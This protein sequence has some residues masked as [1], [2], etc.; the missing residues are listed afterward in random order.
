[1]GYWKPAIGYVLI[2]LVGIT[3]AVGI[4]ID[5]KN[6]YGLARARYIDNSRADSKAA[7]R[8]VEVAYRSIYE[9]LRT[10]S[11]LPGVMA[12]DRHGDNLTPE[13]L[14]TIQQIYNN[15]A[16]NVSISE[17][18]ILPA[19]F[20]PDRTDPATGKGEMPILEFDE[21]V[22]NARARHEAASKGEKLDEEELERP[23]EEIEIF[24][25]RELMKQLAW[26][27]INYP[28]A[29]SI[30]G[31]KVPLVSS[32]EVIT[33]DNTNFIH[34][35]KDSD[36]L[37]VIFSVPFYDED[38]ALKGAISAIV[39]TSVLGKMLPNDNY[40]IVNA[41]RGYSSS[42]L[43]PRMSD[44]SLARY[45]L[46][47]RS[48]I[49]SETIPLDV[50]DDV[51]AWHLWAGLPD[52]NFTDSIEVSS[53]RTME[54]VAEASVLGLTL[55][56]MVGWM[57]VVRTISTQ[58]RAS[59]LL[60]QR[61]DERT[62][63]IQHIATHDTLTG[64]PN[65]RMLGGRM[66]ALL[67]VEG[68]PP[69]FAVH[70]I[71]LDRFKPVNDSL[72]HLVGDELLCFVAKRLRGCAQKGVLIARFGGDEFIVL[73]TDARG[74]KD[75][76]K[77]AQRMIAKLSEEFHVQGH[78]VSIGASVGIAMYP[79]DGRTSDELIRN[80]DLALYRA[81]SEGRGVCRTFEPAMYQD[82]QEAR[83]L[84]VELREAIQRKQFVLH[85][86]PLHDAATA[87]LVGF[88]ALVR[89]NHPERG[90]LLPGSFIGAAEETGLIRHL[91]AW[92]LDQACSDAAEWPSNLTVAVNISPVQFGSESLPLQVV[93]ALGNAGLPPSRLELEIT[94]SVM[95]AENEENVR[96]LHSLRRMG[97]RIAMDD[98]GTG[99]SALRYLRSFP[100]DRIKID[101][102][103][104]SRMADNPQGR[105]IVRAIA[106]L[107]R[108]LGISTTA[109]GV[110][111]ESDL[112]LVRDSGCTDAQGYHFGRP[113]PL[114]DVERMLKGGQAPAKVA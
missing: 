18:Y 74:R 79:A 108:S 5:I 87:R 46:P 49:Y 45:L 70:C 37:G 21:L 27:R 107:A 51:S 92:I 12:I 35:G 68:G 23:A 14:T 82:M 88:E 89:W 15:L 62:A 19:D 101:R 76:E 109:E 95:L 47:D 90:L 31:M 83:A 39:L 61:V 41:S 93:S 13:A 40:T 113:M 81:K 63:E 36:R 24:E 99:Y 54:H 69:S 94:E 60:E 43:L 44:A 64:L 96:T 53:I 29:A 9:N 20:D 73:Q 103:F 110:E 58:R 80:A 72:G 56:A 3:I 48:L 2:L 77:L 4:H 104:V 71:D 97:I 38:G 25:H 85:Y 32:S 59:V 11:F 75:A 6:D 66:D 33:C 111:T 16:S 1:M 22:V 28:T 26:L 106:D 67:S 52:N 114:A 98:F 7:A 84:E 42:K 17:V 10:I 105:A 100:F 30:D 65:R 86:Q 91:G 102:S 112:A 8:H 55:C 78:R 57:F 34:T 50:E